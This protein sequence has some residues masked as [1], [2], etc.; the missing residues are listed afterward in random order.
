VKRHA[1][2]DGFAGA[3]TRLRDA[4]DALNQTWP[5]GWSPDDLIDAMQTGDRL[6]YHPELAREQ[7][8]RMYAMLPKLVASIDA[9]GKNLSE[10]ERQALAQRLNQEYQGKGEK[11]IAADYRDKLARARAAVMDI[12]RAPM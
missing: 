6:S 3:L 11:N 7:I 2:L 9:L 4:Y 10:Q 8:P 1:E 12:P 5:I